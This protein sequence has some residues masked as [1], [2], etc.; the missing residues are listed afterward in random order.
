[1]SKLF[2]CFYSEI[3]YKEHVG[4]CNFRKLKKLMPS[5]KKYTEFENLKNCILNDWVIHSDSECV[6]DSVTKKHEFIAGGYYLECRNNKFS[7]K[8]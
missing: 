6:I 5:F 1:M 7:K 3:K 4:Y 2:K 8:V